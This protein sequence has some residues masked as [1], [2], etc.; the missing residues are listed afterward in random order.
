MSKPK[1]SQYLYQYLN[2]NFELGE[3]KRGKGVSPYEFLRETLK[4]TA[5]TKW[6]YS[7]VLS[8]ERA[9]VRSVLQGF[10]E[11]GM[12]QKGGIAAYIKVKD[13]RGS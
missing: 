6:I 7:Y 4:G 9:I 1:Q 3:A 11:L 2:H 13:N 10:A 8:L 12:C 5:K